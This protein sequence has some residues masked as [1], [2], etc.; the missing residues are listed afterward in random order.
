MYERAIQIQKPVP[1][2]DLYLSLKVL[3]DHHDL[4][5]FVH[6]DLPSWTQEMSGL[7][8]QDPESLI[9]LP[10]IVANSVSSMPEVSPNFLR[11]K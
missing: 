6:V 8:T 3:H 4:Y 1:R 2:N 7:L 10:K 5:K 11:D 9:T